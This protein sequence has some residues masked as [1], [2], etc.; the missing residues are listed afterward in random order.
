MHYPQ[1]RRRYDGQYHGVPLCLP[2]GVAAATV[3]LV[4]LLLRPADAGAADAYVL[5]NLGT[6]VHE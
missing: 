6:R 5:P 4:L 2:V 3:L 1:R